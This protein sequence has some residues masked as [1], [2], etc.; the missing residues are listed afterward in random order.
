MTFYNRAIVTSPGLVTDLYQLTMAQG[1][2][3]HGLAERKAV[4]QL[5]FRRAPF[6][7]RFLL[8]CGVQAVIDFLQHW[9]F[10][11]GD[12][13]YLATLSTPNGKPLFCAE[14]LDYLRQITFRGEVWGVPEGTILFPNEPILRVQAPLVIAQLLETPLLNVIGFASLVATKAVRICRAAAPN[15]VI[16]FGLRRAQGFEA[17]LIASRA[18]Y[19]G[20][21]PATSNVLAGSAFGIPV[22]GTQAHSWVLSFDDESAAFRAYAASYPTGCILVVDTF[23]TIDGIRN[24]IA[25]AQELKGKDQ[26]LLGI[27]LDSGDL[28]KLSRCAREMLDDAGLHDVMILASGDLDEYRIARLKFEGACVDS[29]G[30]GTRLAT[31]FDEPALAVVYKLTAIQNERGEWEDKMK[32]SSE[33]AKRTIPGILQVRRFYSQGRAVCDLLYDERDTGEDRESPRLRNQV[34]NETKDLL[35]QLIGREGRSSYHPDLETIR[36]YAEQEISSIP[37]NVLAIRRSAPFKVLL[38]RGIVRRQR[39]L[40]FSKESNP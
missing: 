15:P 10:S 19:V 31:A 8:V 37:E 27:R 24:A 28:A 36:R 6:G 7:G 18:A 16:E 35:I 11:E 14:F 30:V 1:Y 4:F 3:Q 32:I 2:W 21:C 20:G 13:H 25:V 22:R 40:Q 39:R 29:W 33:K 5:F 12:L 38:S 23:N 26:R 9:R 17:G 34:S